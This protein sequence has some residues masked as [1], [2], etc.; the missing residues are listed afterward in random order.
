M[1]NRKAYSLIEKQFASKTDLAGEPYLDHLCRVADIAGKSAVPRIQPIFGGGYD[2]VYA[3][4][5]EVIGLLHDI[6]E[7]TDITKQYLIDEFG[8]E[9]ADVVEILTRKKHEKY[10]DYIVRISAN[11]TATIVKIADL[12]DNMDIKRLNVLTETDIVRLVKYHKSY[13]FLTSCIQQ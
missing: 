6:L 9:I 8:Q 13:K 11:T 5:L 2:S 7:D 3:N 10:D 1:L 12:T 4:K